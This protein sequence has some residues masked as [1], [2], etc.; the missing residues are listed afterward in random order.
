MFVDQ[1]AYTLQNNNEDMPPPPKK[2]IDVCS[3]IALLLTCR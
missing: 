3:H 2:K 1:A